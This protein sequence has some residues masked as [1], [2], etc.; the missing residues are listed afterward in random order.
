LAP[1][2]SGHKLFRGQGAFGYN[3]CTDGLTDARNPLDEEFGVEGIRAV[4]SQ[5]AGET[6]LN[7]LGTIFRPI[8]EFAG[9]CRQSDDMTATIFLD[10]A[11]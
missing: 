9:D 3:T 7:L 10:A 4:S 1:P 8:E 11:R 2:E 5:H 6:L